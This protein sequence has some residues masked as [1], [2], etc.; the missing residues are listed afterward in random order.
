MRNTWLIIRREYLDKVRTK[1]F[2]IS[3][4]AMPLIIGVLLLP[5]RLATMKSETTTKIVIA[6][7]D[8]GLA[9]QVKDSL[10]HSAGQNRLTGNSDAAL[11]GHF[12]VQLAPEM[13]EQQRDIL[14]DRLS[15]K[16][17]DGFLWLGNQELADRKVP[18]VCRESADFVQ[19]SALRSALENAVI[20]QALSMR[21]V[22]KT[23][24]N[25]LLQ[26]I[27]LDVKRVDRGKETRVDTT[28]NFFAYYAMVMMLYFIVLIYGIAVMRSVIE[29]KSSRVMEVILSCITPRELL[30]GKI[31]GVASVG[32]TQVLIWVAVV[33]LASAPGLAASDLLRKVHI[34]T[35]AMVTFP[36]FFL[37]GYLLYATIYAA[38]GAAINTEQEGQQLQFIIMSPLI[39]ALAMVIPVIQHPNSAFATWMSMIP[40]ISPIV[41]Y[42]R[43]AV[44]TPP[45]WQIALS[46]ALLVATIYGLLVVCARIY[47]VGILMYGK[48]PTLP[49]I[50]R[51]IRYA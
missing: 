19:Q 22:A 3:T 46:I 42:L 37:L 2:I 25:N 11:A 30:A 27:S 15:R 44:E 13:S 40:V 5:G 41:M 21:G 10:E 29:E 4:L 9:Q 47:R 8:R 34:S 1:G 35:P 18:Y 43:I 39:L 36:I 48:R 26:D 20:V 23:D 51:W 6:A 16:E 24:V 17:I 14:R 33:M 45:L 50:I 7:A 28:A 38:L 31:I 32:L 12:D 49:E